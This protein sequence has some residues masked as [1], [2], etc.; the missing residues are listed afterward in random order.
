MRTSLGARTL[1][2][3]T[4]VWVIATYDGAGK[5]NAMTASW[6]GV[7]CSKPPCIAVS[8]RKA[9]Y[10]FGCVTARRAFTVNVPG[11]QQVAEADFLGTASGRDTDKLAAAGLTAVRSELVDAPIIAE[12]PLVLECRVI[13]TFEIGLHTQFIGEILDVKADAG[14]IGEDGLPDPRLVAPMTYA[15][16][17]RRYFGT[18]EELGRAGVVGARLRGR[19]NDRG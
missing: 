2:V 4:P 9:T 14:V 13:H 19:K 1:V 16:E 15:P 7:C 18:G 11:A 6:A 10:T 17:V 5:P 8:L 12:F 3:P